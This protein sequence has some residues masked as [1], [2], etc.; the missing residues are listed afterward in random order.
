MSSHQVLGRLGSLLVFCVA[1]F[2]LT[3]A[4]HAL[5]CGQRLVVRG[6]RAA[7]VR[8]V[9]GE[10]QSATTRTE[11][12]SVGGY[13][14]VAPGTATFGVTTVTVQVDTW[15]YDF[16]PTRFMEELTFENGILTVSRAIGPGTSRR[17][18]PTRKAL[19]AVEKRSIATDWPA[20]ES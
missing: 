3:S 5:D 10:P 4:A 6:D 11:T 18:A 8:S 19:G 20:K 15:I 14:R 1:S 16:G 2:A 7:Y 17:P 13:N 12:R 9:C